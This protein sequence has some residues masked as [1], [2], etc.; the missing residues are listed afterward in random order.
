M[1][2]TTGEFWKR[3]TSQDNAKVCVEDRSFA[4]RAFLSLEMT[5]HD[6][7]VQLLLI[8][9]PAAVLSLINVFERRRD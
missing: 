6:A 3:N 7:I 2:C 1:N 5:I 4:W 8:V 9:I